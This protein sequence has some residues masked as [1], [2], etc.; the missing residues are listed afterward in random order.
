GRGG[1]WGQRWRR[2]PRYGAGGGTRRLA[3]CGGALANRAALG[4]PRAGG[5]MA[6]AERLKRRN[7]GGA[8]ARETVRRRLY[9]VMEAGHISNWMV[10]LFEAG[11]ITLILANVLA[12]MLDSV[13]GIGDRYFTWFYWFETVSIL[14]FAVEYSLRLWVCIEDP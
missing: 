7:R 8:P 9:R 12:V 5:L 1:T 11:L 6:R 10:L 13:K 2:P 3:R 14:I 4:C